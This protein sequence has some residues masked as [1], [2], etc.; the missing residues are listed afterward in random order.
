MVLS[1]ERALTVPHHAILSLKGN[2]KRCGGDALRRGT[3]WLRSCCAA[4]LWA[5]RQQ[6]QQISC[7]D[8]ILAAAQRLPC[9]CWLC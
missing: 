5:T 2:T 1:R 8:H 4:W 7:E 6:S 9:C 3:A